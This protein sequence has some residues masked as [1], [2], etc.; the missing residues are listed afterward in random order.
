M[1][2]RGNSVVQDLEVRAYLKLA[3]IDWFSVQGCAFIGGGQAQL[4]FAEGGAYEH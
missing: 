4:K 3:E 1:L 2:C